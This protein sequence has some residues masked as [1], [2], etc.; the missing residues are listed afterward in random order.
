MKNVDSNKINI[1]EFLS[2]LLISIGIPFLGKCIDSVQL[3]WIDKYFGDGAYNIIS[4][5][6]HILSL[7][8]RAIN[9]SAAICMLTSGM[10]IIDKI[11]LKKELTITVASIISIITSTVSL[12]LAIVMLTI[13]WRPIAAV[14][15]SSLDI[16]NNGAIFP[17][18]SMV[19][20]L[21]CMVIAIILFFRK[22]VIKAIA[23]EILFTI[24]L[25]FVLPSLTSLLA[26]V[27]QSFINASSTFFVTIFTISNRV[28]S[29]VLMIV[30]ISFYLSLAV[31]G[32][33]IAY[34]IHCKSTNQSMKYSK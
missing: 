15:V 11:A 34:K 18:G 27:Q 10:R 22:K 4:E 30:D 3:I 17:I 1:I 24:M 21:V 32:M 14:F 25:G 23:V 8:I 31:C 26:A 19:Y 33:L 28:M 12:L 5:T 13:L 29:P 20:I 16:I 9:L 7:P 6:N 2:I